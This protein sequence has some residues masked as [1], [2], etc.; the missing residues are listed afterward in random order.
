MS[1]QAVQ[2]EVLNQLTVEQDKWVRRTVDIKAKDIRVMTTE[3][4]R[5]T[6]PGKGDDEVSTINDTRFIYTFIWQS[7]LKIKA[8]EL[9]PLKGNL[10][11]FWYRE[12][13]PLVK[14]HNLLESDEG[15][16]ISLEVEKSIRELFSEVEDRDIKGLLRGEG[17]EGYLLDK[18]SKCF[19]QFV[20]R[21]FFRFQGEFKFQD[22]REAFRL[23]GR[24]RPRYVFF[25]EKEGLFWLCEEI[26]EEHGITVIASH[27]EPGYL[28]MEYFSDAL[29]AKEVKNIELACLT[30]YDPWGYNIAE[31]FREKLI[32]PI[33]GFKV[34][35]TH[36]TSLDLFTAEAIEYKKRDLSK[37]SPSK[38]KQVDEWMK[39]TGGIY[40][41]AFGMHVDNAEVDLIEKAVKKW[42]KQVSKRR[43][44]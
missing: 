17:R 44:K 22:P 15:P 7:Y 4:I 30:D 38:K 2:E 21:G 39:E 27:G 13:G 6:F 29:K 31:S 28:T 43:G 8:K 10:R 23:I 3:E 36:L 5:K 41:K 42:L 40:G 24:K 18:M 20:L 14:Y 26:W 25:T 16:A 11:S 33:F 35:K 32:E 1:W 19:D 9:K 12:L 34:N 37:V